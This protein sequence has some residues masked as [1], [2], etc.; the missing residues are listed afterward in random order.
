[1]GLEGSY[2]GSCGKGIFYFNENVNCG[3]MFQNDS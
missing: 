1:M 2:G 3:I